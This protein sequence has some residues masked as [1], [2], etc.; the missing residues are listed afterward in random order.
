MRWPSSS[1]Y[2]VM[3]MVWCDDVMMWCDGHI[4]G[5]LTLY[6]ACGLTG[7]LLLREY[8][9]SNRLWVGRSLPSDG[10][11]VSKWASLTSILSSKSSI[12]LP[13]SSSIARLASSARSNL[14]CNGKHIFFGIFTQNREGLNKSLSSREWMDSVPHEGFALFVSVVHHFCAWY[15]AKSHKQL[16]QRV[17][18]EELWQIANE[19]VVLIRMSRRIWVW[20]RHWLYS[21]APR[22][23]R[24]H[25]G[26]FTG[27]DLSVALKSLNQRVQGDAE[28]A[29][30]S[31]L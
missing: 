22:G 16:F 20:L 1:W 5:R 19:Q 24:G 28:T 11:W 27:D 17:L 2:D 30:C 26:H 23:H 6:W 18:S 9:C 4:G 3:A 13:F 31:E 14:N 21:L 10:T 15:F 8:E 12:R 29:A 7:W 25:Q